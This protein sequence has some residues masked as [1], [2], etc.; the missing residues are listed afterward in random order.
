MKLERLN[1]FG[2]QFANFSFPEGIEAQ[3]RQCYE[4]IG[5]ILEA[6]GSSLH[7]IADQT[8]FFTGDPDEATA[9]TKAV[10]RDVFGDNPPASATVGVA[11]LFDPR[12]RLEMKVTAYRG[13]GM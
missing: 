8:M 13:S 11:Q 7:D 4:N 5:Y 12:C 2:D 1:L 9:A 3:M 10:R 6:V